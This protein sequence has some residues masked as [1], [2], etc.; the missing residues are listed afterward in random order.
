MKYTVHKPEPDDK[1]TRSLPPHRSL[2][3][4]DP[5]VTRQAL[6]D[7]IY[8][9]L[10]HRILT[11]RL[12]PG[13]RLIE[14]DLCSEMNVSRTPLREAL[15]RLGLEGLITLEPYKGYEVAPLG[16][17]DIRNLSELRGI[18]E[19][20]TAALAAQRATPAEIDA[21]SRMA[22]LRYRPGDR[23]TYET[24]LRDNSAFHLALARCS[25][26]DRLESIVASVIDQIQRPL[27]LGLDVGLD[28]NEATREHELVVDAVRRRDSRSARKL[29]RD[30]IIEAGQ[31]SER[32]W[33]DVGSALAARKRND[34]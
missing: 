3:E 16:I 24:Y 11:C 13:V 22:A 33:T 10:K 23:A 6:P 17:E 5:I 12:L 20:E 30:Q 14:K 29:M 9:A 31:R 19:S 18:V 34:G 2:V 15:N 7:R 25:H 32:R 27:Y 21:L 8:A 4:L 26:N 1:A 28:A